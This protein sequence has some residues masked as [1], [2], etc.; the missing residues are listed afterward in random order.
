MIAPM[1]EAMI[2]PI[3]PAA[4]IPNRPNNQPPISEPMTPTT[5]L[6]ITPK[7]P[8]LHD[9]SGKPPGDGA[10]QQKNDETYEYHVLP[11]RSP[12]LSRTD[13]T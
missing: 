1:T 3:S 2:E 5:I 11:R 7:P 9:H 10:D 4:P 13:A 8:P 6:P 12:T